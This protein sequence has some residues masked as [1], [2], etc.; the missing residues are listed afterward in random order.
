MDAEVKA[1][2]CAKRRVTCEIHL[3]IGTN[4]L[5]MARGENLCRNPQPMCP[6]EAGEGY[7]KCK[8]VCQQIGHA[9]EVALM[10][11]EVAMQAARMPRR[12]PFTAVVKGHERVCSPCQAKLEEA[13]VTKI[14]V[15]PWIA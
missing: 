3:Q 2:P 5:L 8:T 14:E 12:G 13:G 15:M 7:E 4:R 6:R 11:L 10:N 1:G 9:E